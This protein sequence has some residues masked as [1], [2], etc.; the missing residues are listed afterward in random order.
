M[1]R[2]E[3]IE[4]LK[5]NSE[6]IKFARTNFGFCRTLT[7]ELRQEREELKALLKECNIS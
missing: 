6:N 3:I 2:Q 7:N 5:E 4:K 1:T